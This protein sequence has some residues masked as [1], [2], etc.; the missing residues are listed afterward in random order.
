L[1]KFDNGVGE[2]GAL[3]FSYPD[4]GHFEAV[5]LAFAS[6]AIPTDDTTGEPASDSKTLAD[7]IGDDESN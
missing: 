3:I 6:Q 1:P 2:D 4:D 5:F 7:I